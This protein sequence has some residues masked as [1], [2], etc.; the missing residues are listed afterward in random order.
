[1]N[2]LV[3]IHARILRKLDQEVTPLRYLDPSPTQEQKSPIPTDEQ[4]DVAIKEG[5]FEWG[6]KFKG[7]RRGQTRLVRRSCSHRPI[8]YLLVVRRRVQV[9]RCNSEAYPTVIRL[10]HDPSFTD[11]QKGKKDKDFLRSVERLKVTLLTMLL[12]TGLHFKDDHG[13]P[14]DLDDLLVDHGLLRDKNGEM[15][16]H[17]MSIDGALVCK[18]K[19]KIQADRED[20]CA[21]SKRSFTFLVEEAFRKNRVLMSWAQIYVDFTEM[22]HHRGRPSD[23]R[24]EGLDIVCVP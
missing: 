13:S 24:R 21:I 12:D 11:A 2:G 1:M 3:R 8:P 6:P 23:C 19:V 14:M 20:S 5:C 17:G 9:G 18:I 10:R 4:R 22:D 15:Y 7:Y 16:L